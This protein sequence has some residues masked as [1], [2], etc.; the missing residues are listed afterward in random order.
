M[1]YIF[2]IVSQISNYQKKITMIGISIVFTF[3]YAVN[4]LDLGNAFLNQCQCKQLSSQ[5]DCLNELCTWSN[6]AC[7]TPACSTY[8]ATACPM[9]TNCVYFGGSCVTWTKCSDYNQTSG[10]T[11]C[12]TM[13]GQCTQSQT[14]VSNTTTAVL[15]SCTDYV[16]NCTALSAVN[17]A[18]QSACFYNTTA[19]VCRAKACSDVT[20][21]AGCTYVNPGSLQLSTLCL[22]NTTSS[23]CGVAPDVST[24]TAST[25]NSYTQTSYAW[26]PT[27]SKCVQCSTM[28]SWDMIASITALIAFVLA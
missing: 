5:A 24:L 25:C 13:G 1:P 19:A 21:S 26:N 3:L 14:V 8:N 28:S 10:N 15:Y 20:T 17:C 18:A 4:S 12:M 7:T 27:T 6:G 22:W 9:S 2:T 23:T 11:T 16:I